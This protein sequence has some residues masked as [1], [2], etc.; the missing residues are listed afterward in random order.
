MND[1]L[2][3]QAVILAGGKGSRLRPITDKIPKPMV[4]V[5]QVPFL[6]Y[7]L[8]TIYD[9]GIKDILILTGYKSEVIEEHYNQRK[10][11]HLNIQ[12]SKGEINYKTGKRLIHA[13]DKLDSHFL[14]LYGDNYWPIDINRMVENYIKMNALVSTTVFS[15]LKGTGEY[16]SQNNVQVLNN[17]V[18]QYDKKR[19]IKNLN[20]VDIGFFIVDKSVIDP[21]NDSNLSFEEDML[22]GII[23]ENKLAAYITDNQY[24][25]ITNQKAL[26]NFEK[27]AIK[28]NYKTL[29]N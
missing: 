5:N 26:S 25:Y 24:Y 12:F 14:L 3:K 29:K 8:K 15:N 28:N 19:N 16:G 17:L 2:I 1:V 22:P 13:Y 21:F 18:H 6:D 10:I 20:G 7:L 23:R 27:V 4:R 9:A 11:K